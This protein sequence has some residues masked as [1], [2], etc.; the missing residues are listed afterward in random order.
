[1]T[2]YTTRI[3]LH[4]AQDG[5]YG[6][7]HA[8]ME[9]KGVTRTIESDDGTVYQLPTAEYN[10]IGT[11]TRKEVLEL[12]KNAAATVRPKYAVLVTQSA[13]R[14]WSGLEKI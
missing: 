1:M 14:T 8:A 3:E 6:K 12:A 13:G 7:L 10:F 11:E 2:S 4:K 9:K 5:D